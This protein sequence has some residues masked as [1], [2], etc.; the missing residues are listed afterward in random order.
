MLYTPL[1]ND[2]FAADPAINH[3][4]VRRARRRDGPRL[5]GAGDRIIPLLYLRVRMAAFGAVLTTPDSAVCHFSHNGIEGPPDL[6]RQ[7]GLT[8]GK[9]PQ[10]RALANYAHLFFATPVYSH[11]PWGVLALLLAGPAAA[12]GR[13]PAIWPSRDCCWAPWFSP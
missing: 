10:D 7:L 4:A 6:L 2:P 11:I 8:P 3:G 12:A 13:N 5:E 9:R 1:R